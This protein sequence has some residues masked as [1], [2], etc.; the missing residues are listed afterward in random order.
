MSKYANQLL[1]IRLN[2]IRLEF[3][4][5]GE[6][7]L[8][9]DKLTRTRT[10]PETIVAQCLHG[11]YE[12]RTQDTTAVIHPG[13]I[14]IIGSDMPFT[15]IHH[16]D[17]NGIMSSRF[18]HCQFTV[19]DNIDF[20]TLLHMPL[21]ITGPQAAQIGDHIGQL[22]GIASQPTKLVDCAYTNKL[23]FSILY[24]L[25]EVSRPKYSDVEE[26]RYTE[27]LD[28]V[29]A[30]I[31]EHIDGSISVQDLARAANMS[32]SRFFPYFKSQVKQTPMD[33]VKK[34]RISRACRY[35][36]STEQSIATIAERVGFSNQFHFSR[37]FKEIC[38]ETPSVYR[39]QFT[40]TYYLESN[41]LN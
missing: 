26:I 23:A 16:L 13:E 18:I 9:S 29:F 8:T 22:L 36:V 15:N 31:A 24:D 7:T 25:C 20:L 14:A 37:V 32:L 27:R 19:F 30:Y 5:V 21:K 17:A 33:Y 6:R 11:R 3:I 28:P 34:T 40:R 4:R 39:S 10:L 38:G 35:L 41:D 2:D 12:V 1:N